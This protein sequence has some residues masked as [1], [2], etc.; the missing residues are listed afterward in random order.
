[1]NKIKLYVYP[2][3]REHVHDDTEIYFNT[4]PLSKKG[5]EDYCELVSPEEADYFYMGQIPNDHFNRYTSK[6]FHDLINIRLCTT[7][8][9]QTF[10]LFRAVFFIH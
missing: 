1:M 9:I 10:I 7:R 2:N 5:I 4:V 6:T 3:A 8:I